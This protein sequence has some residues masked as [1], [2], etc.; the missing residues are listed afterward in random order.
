[1]KI[2]CYKFVS[3]QLDKVSGYLCIANKYIEFIFNI[4]HQNGWYRK[5]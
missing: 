5:N 1:M 3:Y 4:N 2:M